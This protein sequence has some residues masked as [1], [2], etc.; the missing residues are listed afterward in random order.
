MNP[1]IIQIKEF[2]VIGITGND[3][4]QVWTSFTNLFDTFQVKGQNEPYFYEIEVT[5]QGKDTKQKI[6]H[7]G[8]K[9]FNENQNVYYQK[10]D[11]PGF[12]YAS[13]II[14]VNNNRLNESEKEEALNWLKNNHK[15][16]QIQF[17]ESKYIITK[18]DLFN[19]PHNCELWIPIMEK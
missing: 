16:K 2:P 8:V 12:T 6:Y 4:N 13:F 11:V 15:Y 7:V 17:G 19:N 9:S 14:N 5:I 18:Y 3:Q 1:N 10:K